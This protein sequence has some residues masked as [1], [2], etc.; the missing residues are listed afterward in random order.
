MRWSQP[1]LALSVP[2]SR[3]TSLA[4]GGSAWVVSCHR[5]MT[6]QDKTFLESILAIAAACFAFGFWIRRKEGAAHAWPQSSGVITASKTV[7]QYV[8]RGREEVF[9]VIEYS[10]GYQGQSFKSSHWRLGNY[11][12]GTSASAEIVT[13]RYPVGASVTVFVNPRQPLKSVLEHRP[14]SLCWVPFGFG[15][16][17]LAIFILASFILIMKLQR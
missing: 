10:F 9:P 3:F 7:R 13:S 6:A 11:S 4:P 8:D 16:F 12:V 14:S 2:L 5:P 17:L 1:G 15:I